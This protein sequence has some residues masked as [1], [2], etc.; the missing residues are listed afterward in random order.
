[1]ADQ[2][3]PGFCV[4]MAGGRGTRFWPLSRTRR[5]KQLL[6]LAG[7]TSLLRDTVERVAPLVGYDRILV[8]T[9]GD[10]A[11]VCAEQLP[12]LATDRIIAEPVGRNTAPCAV[13]GLGIAARLAGDAPVALLPAD[14]AIPDAELFRAQLAAAFA[15]AG[16]AGGVL[17]IG[18]PPT[19]PETGYGYL[20]TG[21]DLDG[22]DDVQAGVAFVEKPDRQR[23]EAYLAGGRHVWNSGIFVWDAAAFRAAA[24]THVPDMVAQLAPAIAAHGT[25]DFDDALAAAYARCP[26]DSIDYAVME[27]LPSFAVMRARFQWSD[28]GSW[29]AWGDLAPELAGPNRGTGEL[30]AV[31]SRD[32]VVH[33][34]DK[35]VTLVGVEDLVIVDTGDALLVCRRDQDQRVKEIIDRLEGDGRSDLL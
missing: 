31:D 28:L 7:G 20:E 11:P 24:D 16:R 35:L 30:I 5:P 29:S 12:E 22:V 27:K 8:I 6:P 21:E 32:N 10:L 2:S 15:Q 34:A 1:M 23:A 33:A 17:T 26:A 3:S 13:L 18:I 4:I 19:R 14:H 25:P 9:S